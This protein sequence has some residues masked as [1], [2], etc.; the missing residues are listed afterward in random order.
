MLD[1][2]E[3]LVER[4]GKFHIF[5][6]VMIDEERF[7]VLLN[8]IRVALPDDIRRATEITRQGERVLEQAQQKARE[9]I[10]RAK[11]EAAQL[12]ARDEI[13]RRAEEEARRI[14]A[15]AE[16]QAK[17]VRQEAERY[18]QETR[19]AAEDYAREVLGRLKGVLNRAV[20]AI[21]EGIRELG[22]ERGE[23]RKEGESQ[24]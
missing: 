2:L 14:I 22:S 24:R 15:R 8:K 7:F 11:Q 10:E 5:G 21:D 9:V 18:A 3:Q 16:E 13:V 1:E 12:V 20:S 23:G 6:K 4:E 17:K 19:R